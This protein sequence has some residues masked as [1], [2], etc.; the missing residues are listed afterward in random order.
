MGGVEGAVAFQLYTF[1]FPVRK[2]ALLY[3]NPCL[4]KEEMSAPRDPHCFFERLYYSR[5]TSAAAI[6]R[7]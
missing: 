7:F 1:Q 5:A 3:F 2:T 6:S 4:T